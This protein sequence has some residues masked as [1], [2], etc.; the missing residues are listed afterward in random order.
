MQSYTLLEEMHGKISPKYKDRTMIYRGKTQENMCCRQ[1]EI[2]KYYRHIKPSNI[3]S[4]CN[5]K[6]SCIYRSQGEQLRGLIRDGQG[7]AIF[8]VKEMIKPVLSFLIGREITIIIDDVPLS[9]VL[10]PEEETDIDNLYKISKFVSNIQG[11]TIIPELVPMLIDGPLTDIRSYLDG[12]HTKINRELEIIERHVIE[13]ILTSSNESIP[14]FR[15]IYSLIKGYGQ[16]HPFTLYNKSLNEMAPIK[17]VLDESHHLKQHRVF[18]LNATPSQKDRYC[19]DILG[20]YGSP[21]IKDAE[22]NDNYLIIQVQDAKYPASGILQNPE[23]LIKKIKT[24]SNDAIGALN[25]LDEKAVIFVKNNVY[26][27]AFESGAVFDLPHEHVKFFGKESKGTN[28]HRDK[29]MAIIP[30]TPILP[31]EAYYHPAYE[32]VMKPKEE[33][34]KE[35][36]QNKERTHK[37]PVYPVQNEIIENDSNNE[38]F[39]ML[40]RIFRQ[41]E[42]NPDKKKVCILFSNSEI[43]QEDYMPQNGARIEKCWMNTEKGKTSIKNRLKRE[44]KGIFIPKI[45]EKMCQEIEARLDKG[46]IISL[47]KFAESGSDQVKIMSA[48]KLKIELELRYSIKTKPFGQNN[49][50]TKFIVGKLS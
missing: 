37:K 42:S 32:E 12:N 48:T 2:K 21:L 35:I 4:N 24:V 16:D 18:Y 19:M 31:P 10:M 33:I 1:E 13:T 40:G 14:D 28:D 46:E 20:D 41:D 45:I 29:S 27:R 44:Y 36:E 38:I 5:N 34:E 26:S 49:R 39:Q 3:C 50:N 23:P 7:I 9:D 43:A 8:T 6:E 22:P 47:H 11:T 30:G 25:Y 17:V 15:I